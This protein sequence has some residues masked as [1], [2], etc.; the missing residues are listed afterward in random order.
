M[1]NS[2]RQWRLKHRPVGDIKPG[3]LE[4]SEAPKP[5]PGPG[6]ILVRNVYLS[7]DPTNRIWMSDMEQ[8]MPPVVIGDVMRGGT[9]GIVEQSNAPGFAVGD[10][11]MPGMGGWQDYSLGATS[12]PFAWSLLPL[13]SRARRWGYSLNRPRSASTASRILRMRSR[14]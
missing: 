8:Y 11:A 2:N 4:L 14:A 10:I 13:T 7:L 3:D 5:V 6:E 1:R 9:I 12:G